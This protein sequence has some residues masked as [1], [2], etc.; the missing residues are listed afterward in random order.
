MLQNKI[1]FILASFLAVG[2]AILGC[3]FYDS[4][5]EAGNGNWKYCLNHS[6]FGKFASL[7]QAEEV[8]K[9][10]Q[11]NNPFPAAG[12]PIDSS[13]NSS[14]PITANPEGFQVPL[15]V[16]KSANDGGN[17]NGG[18]DKISPEF[19]DTSKWKTYENRKYGYS[20]KYPA[21]YNYSPCDNASPCKIGQAYEKDG[22]DAAWL[23]SDTN[24]RG[25]PYIIVLHYDSESF[26]LPKNTKLLDWL[27][28][29]FGQPSSELFKDYNIEIPTSKGD[30]KKAM[31]VS[32]PQTPQAYAREE[33]YFE[34]GNKIFQIQMLDSNNT[35][36]QEFY[37]VWLITF[38]LE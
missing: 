6:F 13:E 14:L 22:G 8:A 5:K 1:I 3:L 9:E 24:N 34:R 31:K 21:E 20:F 23:R 30:P 15:D 28:Q 2:V 10:K 4:C 32:I 16:R 26:T 11:A 33:V 25:W 18:D 36:A 37:N 29:K 27:K 7:N 19:L 38:Q 35:P 12:V 17:S